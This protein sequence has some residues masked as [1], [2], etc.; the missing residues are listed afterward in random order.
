MKIDLQHTMHVRMKEIL[1][2]VPLY[3]EA[4]LSYS[5]AIQILRDRLFNHGFIV[6]RELFG[7]SM[8][9]PWIEELL[10]KHESAFTGE[11]SNCGV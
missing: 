8:A 7:T 4:S 3:G 9:R 11:G 6:L 2:Q 5:T 1:P 10:V